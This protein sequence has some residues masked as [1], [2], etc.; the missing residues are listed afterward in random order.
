MLSS[1]KYWYH[2]VQFAKTAPP[3]GTE[4]LAGRKRPP[5]PRQPLM[6][7]IVIYFSGSTRLRAQYP[8]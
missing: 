2:V 3:A 7:V 6:S 1:A 5:Q 4:I 8:P